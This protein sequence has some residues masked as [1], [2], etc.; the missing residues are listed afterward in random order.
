MEKQEGKPFTSRINVGDAQLTCDAAPA[1][2]GM[3][4]VSMNQ[5]EPTHMN[6]P[7]EGQQVYSPYSP[8]PAYQQAPPS[9]HIYQQP[10][11]H[12]PPPQ[13]EHIYQQPQPYQQQPQSMN[14]PQAYSP[15]AGETMNPPPQQYFTQPMPQQHT[16][17]PQPQFVHQST[18]PTPIQYVYVQSPQPTGQPGMPMQTMAPQQQGVAK[19]GFP[20]ATP[21]QSL[22]LASAPVDCPNCGQRAMTNTMLVS[23]EK[24]NMWALIICFFTCLG[25]I[26]Y[27]MDELKDVQHRCSKVCPHIALSKVLSRCALLIRT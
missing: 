15:P 4:Q 25:C 16:G 3:H 10:N 5:P 22:N 11:P 27:M 23:G 8:A 6:Q 18:G 21:L 2:P 14:A 24:T 26:A 7:V 17:S 12:S 9:E 19:G 1:P 13:A 20:Y